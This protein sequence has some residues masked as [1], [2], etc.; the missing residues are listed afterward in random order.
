LFLEYVQL[1]FTWAQIIASQIQ[2]DLLLLEEEDYDR[3]NWRQR[4]RQERLETRRTAAL[5]WQGREWLLLAVDDRNLGHEARP[6]AT[7]PRR[8]WLE[9]G[10]DR[11]WSRAAG[12]WRSSTPGRLDPSGRSPDGGA[13][14]QWWMDPSPTAA[15]LAAALA[16]SCSARRRPPCP[17]ART[18]P[19]SRGNSRTAAR[20]T[21]RRRW[22]SS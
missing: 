10:G 2:R 3:S 13:S 4:V 1:M 18:P 7:R 9:L 6:A 5:L 11:I 20:H 21:I 19:P 14:R 16:S 12:S 15:I 17:V 8:G 22:A